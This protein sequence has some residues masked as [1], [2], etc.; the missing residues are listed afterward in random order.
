ML[1]EE[2]ISILVE[3][4]RYGQSFTSQSKLFTLLK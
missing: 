2:L 1:R 3:E 4:E